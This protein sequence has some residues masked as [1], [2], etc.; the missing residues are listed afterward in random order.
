MAAVRT[1]SP[2]LS[3]A[4]R[5]GRAGEI[6]GDR[7]EADLR[8]GPR[9]AKGAHE[10]AKAMLLGGDDRFD[11]AA[12][13][14]PRGGST[15]APGDTVGAAPARLTRPTACDVNSVQSDVLTRVLPPMAR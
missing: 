3:A 1:R 9:R 14:R 10:Q 15:T 6:A 5:A 4:R 2:P 7:G 11:G 12:D 13:L 8:R